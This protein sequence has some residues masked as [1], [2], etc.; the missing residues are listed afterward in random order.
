MN[1]RI[2]ETD[3]LERLRLCDRAHVQI[4]MLRK[5]IAGKTINFFE[6]LVHNTKV[7][8]LEHMSKI[9]KAHSEL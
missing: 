8:N 2:V 6:S 4:V 3:Y 1:I 9:N 7:K 5:I